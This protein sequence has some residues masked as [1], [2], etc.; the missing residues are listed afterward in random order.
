VS[1]PLAYFALFEKIEDF[2]TD[3]QKLFFSF[4]SNERGDFDESM[5]ESDKNLW[6][7]NDFG[8]LMKLSKG[9]KCT[10]TLSS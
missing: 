9:S 1:R 5:S 10:T 8:K 3:F 2:S 6:E 4:V 7:K